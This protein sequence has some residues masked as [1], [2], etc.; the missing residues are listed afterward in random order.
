MTMLQ[1]TYFEERQRSKAANAP[2]WPD[3]SPTTSSRWASSAASGRA[4]PKTHWPELKS[5]SCPSV[6]FVHGSSC[7]CFSDPLTNFHFQPSFAEV[8]ADQMSCSAY[9]I[10]AVCLIACNDVCAAVLMIGSDALASWPSREFVCSSWWSASARIAKVR[11]CSTVA[12][13]LPCAA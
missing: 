2:W 5:S 1:Q 7:A 11:V 12:S 6:P 10:S 8:S 4:D 9:G 13:L 3:T